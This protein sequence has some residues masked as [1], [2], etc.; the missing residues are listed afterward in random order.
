MQHG[1]ALIDDAERVGFGRLGG[2]D[3]GDERDAGEEAG[4]AAG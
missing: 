3:P 2:R 1:A 4:D